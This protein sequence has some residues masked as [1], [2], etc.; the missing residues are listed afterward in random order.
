MLT[1]AESISPSVMIPDHRLAMLL[2]YVKRSQISQ[3]L[4]HNNPF[5]PILYSDHACDRRDFPLQPTIELKQHSKEVW[6]CSFSH[7]GTKLV[8]TSQ[9]E[10][11]IIYETGTF[12]VLHKLVGHEG[13]VAHASWSPDD[14]KLVTS[15]Q[16]RKARVW[17]VEVCTCDIFS[18]SLR[19]MLTV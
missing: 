3:C 9:D 11:V 14:S 13:G 7:D 17:S 1:C 4:Y 16:D 18:S 12:S 2:D 8:S 10:T 6:Y 5:V 15:S 19:L